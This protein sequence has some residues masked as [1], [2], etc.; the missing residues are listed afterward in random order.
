[1]IIIT[2]AGLLIHTSCPGS[3]P[4]GCSRYMLFSGGFFVCHGKEPDRQSSVL[5]TDMGQHPPCPIPAQNPQKKGKVVAKTHPAAGGAQQSAVCLGLCELPAPQGQHTS[6]T[7]MATGS[8]G[9]WGFG[10]PWVLV[11]AP[12]LVVFRGQAEH[13][14]RARL[15]LHWQ[16]ERTLVGFLGN[17]VGWMFLCSPSLFPKNPDCGAEVEQEGWRDAPAAPARSREQPTH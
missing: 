16:V 5:S 4:A 1:M 8:S 9:D 6:G 3:V 10:S 12:I 2:V 14:C 13:R 11:D 15:V 17:N 7:R